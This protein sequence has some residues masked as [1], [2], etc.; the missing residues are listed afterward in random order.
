MVNI[1]GYE[2]V[3][4]ERENR[5]GGGVGFLISKELHYNSREDLGLMEEYLECKFIEIAMKGRNVLCGSLYRP[6]N[7]NLKMFQQAMNKMMGK[8]KPSIHDSIVGMDHNLDL[9]KY[10]SH[11][12]TSEFMN[13]L[14]D[15]SMFPC[16]SK[17]TRITKTT[18]TL[19]D[20]IFV[21][22]RL[23][24]SYKSGI[25]LD[26]I[27]DHFPSLIVIQDLFAKKREPKTIVT[28]SITDCKIE[29]LIYDLNGID[30]AKYLDQT[31]PSKDYE[32]FIS[33]LTK[34]MDTHIP[35]RSKQIPVKQYMCEPWITK[36][37][38]KCCKKSLKLYEK[39]LKGGNKMMT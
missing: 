31:D 39:Y 1:P 23:H 37:L 2:F 36:G 22:C 7:S 33:K 34:L 11:I 4:T 30:W 25:I 29:S 13:N 19:I 32:I 12:G 10:N 26:D 9:L 17:P 27:S 3:G 18:A 14:L 38:R 21:N 28:R 20:N 16:I 15:N 8:I 24:A 6:P 5:K 35:L